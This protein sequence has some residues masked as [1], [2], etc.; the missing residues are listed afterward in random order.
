MSKARS[1][2]SPSSETGTTRSTNTWRGK[3]ALSDLV[4]S[5]LQLSAAT[6]HSDRKLILKL[7]SQHGYLPVPEL[8]YVMSRDLDRTPRVWLYVEKEEAA[9]H[10][11]DIIERSRTW[12]GIYAL[13]PGVILSEDKYTLIAEMDRTPFGSVAWHA[14]DPE[15]LVIEW[16]L[17]LWE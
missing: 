15:L 2:Q 6:F 17:A 9:S 11:R 5:E 3:A 1:Q 4:S 10:Y 8:Y 16:L 14:E 12:T 7:L 13:T